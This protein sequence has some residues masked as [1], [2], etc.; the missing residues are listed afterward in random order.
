MVAKNYLGQTR[1]ALPNLP[2]QAARMIN[3]K[4]KCLNCGY[5]FTATEPPELFNV[6]TK[7]LMCGSKNFKKEI[8]K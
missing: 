6:Y 7:C 1:M 2:P 4:F 3:W 5:K 8:K